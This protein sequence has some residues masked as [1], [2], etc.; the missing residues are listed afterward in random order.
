[1]STEPID[2]EQYQDD[3]ASW[4]TSL[5]NVGEV[6]LPC[7]AATEP[8]LLVEV[9]AYAGDLTRLLVDWAAI[10]DRQVRVLAVDPAPQDGL[11]VL[12]RE[13]PEL[14]LI[15]ETSLEALP[16]IDLPEVVILDGD[17]NYWTVS[18]EL[19]LIAQR[20]GG[21]ALPLILL[22]DVIWPHARR[23]DYFDAAQIPADMR[24][25][26]IGDDGGIVPGDDGMRPGGLPYQRS[27]RAAGGPGNGVRTAVEDFVND[28]DGLR[29]ATV[30]AFFGLGIVWHRDAPWADRVAAI[31]D[32]WDQNPLVARLE[33]GRVAHIA[34]EHALNTE[35][36][37]A[38]DRQARQEA[39]LR[40]M[41]ESSAFGVAER[42][43]RLRV[44]LGIAPSQSV[45]SKQEIRR[46]LEP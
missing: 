19:R 33:A 18:E 17:H 43:S 21:A 31:V 46:A 35:I 25:P 42:L 13:R 24:Q 11:V 26:T 45:V 16:R 15:R 7:I 27:A 5:A 14:E 44:R 4:S 10:Q 6:M 12:D 37:A 40:R 34:S 2:L 29:F 23:D 30:P 39:V 3:P 20:G 8:T 9:G 1:M 36:W 32:P 38:R 28:Q 22:H 41:A